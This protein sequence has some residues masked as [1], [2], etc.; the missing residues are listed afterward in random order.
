MAA[1]PA[2]SPISVSLHFSPGGTDQPFPPIGI[3]GHKQLAR[4]KGDE[5]FCPVKLPGD[6]PRC[7]ASFSAADFICRNRNAATPDKRSVQIIKGVLFTW[8]RL[9]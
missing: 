8:H 3:A 5:K 9:S 2:A 7:L 1:L 4:E 6:Y